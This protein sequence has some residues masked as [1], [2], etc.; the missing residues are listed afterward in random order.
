MRDR[1]FRP[2]ANDNALFVTERCNN[3]CVMCCQPPSTADDVDRLMRLN[4]RRLSEA[5]AEMETLAVTGGEPTLLG[6]RLVELLEAVRAKLPNTDIHLLS[7]G[8]R[9]ADAEYCH[10]VCLAAGQ[11]LVVGVPFHSDYGPDHDRIAGARNAYNETMLGLYNLAMQGACI[12]LRIVMNGLNY[13]RFPQ[14]SRFIHKNLSFVGWTA[15]MGMER[16]GLASSNSATCWIEPLRYME[17]LREAVLFLDGWRHEVSIYN[18]PLCLLPEALHR[19]AARS[20]S[21]WKNYFPALCEGC[22]LKGGCC[23]LFSTSSEPYEGLRA[24]L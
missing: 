14:M 5:P 10:R 18:L 15:F 23:G 16:V 6:E 20:I 12:E 11:R 24:S 1:A 19:F 2:A 3:R 21:E 17:Q 9:F 13:T 8:R 7:N 4:L 22:R